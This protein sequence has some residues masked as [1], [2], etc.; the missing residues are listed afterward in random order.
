MILQ[1]RKIQFYSSHNVS[2]IYII[3]KKGEPS[4]IKT[5]E[6]TEL[7]QKIQVVYKIYTTQ[8]YSDLN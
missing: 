8:Q 1:N 3:N 2:T 5:Q 6:G 4:P 7:Q